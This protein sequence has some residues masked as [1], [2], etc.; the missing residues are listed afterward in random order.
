MNCNSTDFLKLSKEIL[1]RGNK[2]RFQARGESM[3][4]FIRDGDILEIEPAGEKKIRLGDVVFYRAGDK[5]AVAHRIVKKITQGNK[6]IFITKGDSGTGEGERVCHEQI[7]GRVETVER[8]GRTIHINKGL[9][10]LLSRLYVGIFPFLM[11]AKPIGSWM[12]PHIQGF[13]IYRYLAKR[14][15]SP[16]TFFQWVSSEDIGGCLL[17]KKKEMVI[18]RITID[19]FSKDDSPYHG[20]WIFSTWVY[21][22]YRRLDIGRRLTEMACDF[23]AHQG[24]PEVKLLVFKD[25]K[26]ALN[27][28]QKMG[29]Y[30]VYIPEIDRML[31]EEFKSTHRK[32]IILKKDFNNK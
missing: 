28:Y 4:P 22:R 24:V 5:H 3:F 31:E 16:E 11:T 13:K 32:R 23:A 18:G 30:Q 27:L 8:A 17:C 12:L 25:S 1:T 21:W 19:N 9:N 6:S 2:L 15:V 26:A 10:R 14:L 20:W 29:F 7:L